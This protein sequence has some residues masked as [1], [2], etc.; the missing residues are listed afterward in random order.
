MPKV[1]D[2]YRSAKRREIAEA[3]LRAFR[4]K[5]FQ[6]TSMAD[7]I[8]ESGLSAGAIYG[9]YASKSDIV[10]EVAT[11]VVGA[12]I[13]DVE[14]LAHL[15]PMPPPGELVPV[16]IRG[17]LRE[18]GDPGILVQLWGE[19][20]TDSDIASLTTNIFLRLR[21]A[22]SSYVSLWQQRAHGLPKPDA[23]QLGRDQVPLLISAA[24]GFIVQSALVPD[25]RSRRL[26]AHP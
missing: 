21:T 14:R 9:H 19:A 5:G 10:L 7:I 3:A 22:L 16:L 2:E 24:Q 11:Q 25:F 15:D 18:V 4:R 26:P 20:V 13:V 8:A 6:G 23:D 1:T 17:M 12:R